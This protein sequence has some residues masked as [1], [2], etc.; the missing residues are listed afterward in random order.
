M[1]EMGQ[2]SDGYHTFDE[3]YQH[4]VALFLALCRALGTGW[5]SSFHADGGRFVG[6]FIVGLT[7]PRVGDITY[8]LPDDQWENAAHLHTLTFAPAWDGH[9]PAEVVERLTQYATLEEVR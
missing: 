8:H 1:S 6:W 9:T 3:L 2:V 4:R 5:R 7:L